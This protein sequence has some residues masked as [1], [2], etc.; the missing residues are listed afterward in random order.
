M[1]LSKLT[2]NEMALLLAHC[3]PVLEDN[4]D[5]IVIIL[6][7]L[8]V[9]T[10]GRF[11]TV[12][13]SWNMVIQKRFFIELQLNRSK[14]NPRRIVFR[15]SILRP[16]LDR[17]L[18]IHTLIASWNGLIFQTSTVPSLQSLSIYNPVT[19]QR[20]VLPEDKER[21][22]GRD[23]CFGLAHGPRCCDYKVYKFVR[24]SLFIDTLECRMYSSIT[25]SW[26]SLGVPPAYPLYS[27]HVF[28]NGTVYWQISKRREGFPGAI[29]AIDELDNFHTFDPP[30]LESGWPYLVTL[31]DSLGIVV[32]YKEVVGVSRMSIWVL[33][34]LQPTWTKKLDTGI[35]LLSLEMTVS[36]A[37]WGNRV[38]ITTPRRYLTYHKDRKIWNIDMSADVLDNKRCTFSGFFTESLLPCKL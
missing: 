3:G 31:G 8:P 2:N 24:V 20:F 38:V 12:S 23:H 34:S 37:A 18:S 30:E 21:P 9:K 10:L 29:L 27:S 7:Y 5:L 17:P 25:G 13:K 14:E 28:L 6:S 32:I 22:F 36:A 26:I 4:L 19:E 16:T 33:E 1:A 15:S 35:P 11:R